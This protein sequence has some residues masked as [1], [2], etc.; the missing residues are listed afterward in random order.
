VYRVV[1][2]GAG[3]GGMTVFHHI[4]PWAKKEQVQLTVIDERETFLLKPSLPEVAMGEKGIQDVTFAVRPVIEAHGTFLCSRVQRIDPEDK[5]VV[6]ED[7]TKI[8]YDTL[9][10]ALGAQKDFRAIPGFSDFG[11]SVCTD[12]LAPRLFQAL[13]EFS[14]GDLVIGSAPMTQGTRTPDVPFLKAA[15]EG[16][17]GEIAFMVDAYLQRRGLREKSRIHCFSPADVFFEDVGDKVHEAFG[18]FTEQHQI[19]IETKKIID[20]L[21]ADKVVFADGT[22]ISSALSILIPA[23]R[24][25]DVVAESHLGDEAGFAPT[26]E[27]FRHLDYPDIYAIGDGAS[28]TVPKLGH[29]AV[30]QGALVASLLHRELTGRGA[31]HDFDP[32]IFCIMNMGNHRAMLIRSNTLYGGNMDIAYYGAVSSFMKKAFDDY[33]LHLKGKMPPDIAQRLLNVYLQRLA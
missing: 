1:I 32:E 13:E 8:F 27:Q 33:L 5:S 23:Y 30:E 3:F 12:V 19:G 29:L 4:V 2:L 22:E 16:P 9:V 15:C 26:D 14:G 20:H 28:R 21:E 24:G 6:L 31:I 7:G 11:H 17:V 18:E 25:P 10:L